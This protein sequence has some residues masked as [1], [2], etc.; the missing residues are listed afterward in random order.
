MIGFIIEGF[1]SFCVFHLEGYVGY[2]TGA[3]PEHPGQGCAA[4][5]AADFECL[6]Y[7]HS[8]IEKGRPGHMQDA[9]I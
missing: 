4:R 6:F 8:Q 3:T 7:N 2:R 5:M 1:L 9:P